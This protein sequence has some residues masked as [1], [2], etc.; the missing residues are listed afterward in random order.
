MRW[1]KP[2]QR[3]TVGVPQ[4]QHCTNDQEHDFEHGHHVETPFPRGAP[5]YARSAA[6]RAVAVQPEDGHRTAGLRFVRRCVAQKSECLQIHAMPGFA[7]IADPDHPSGVVARRQLREE[8]QVLVTLHS[9]PEGR[10]ADQQCVALDGVGA[11][12]NLLQ[13]LVQGE[14][15]KPSAVKKW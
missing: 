5:A 4:A 3:P 10:V 2:V 15:K 6:I 7:V 14:P 12:V 11:I 1:S 9:V 13:V 8:S